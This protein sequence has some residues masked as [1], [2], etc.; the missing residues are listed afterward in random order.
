M[1]RRDCGGSMA[2][3][4]NKRGTNGERKRIVNHNIVIA[5][6][7]QHGTAIARGSVGHR[8]GPV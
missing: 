6:A 3:Q 8:L 5:V 4:V 2:M 7:P 1:M